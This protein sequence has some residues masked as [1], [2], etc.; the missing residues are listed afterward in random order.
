MLH[1]ILH[2]A[3]VG[4]VVDIVHEK[5]KSVYL[6]IHS[7]KKYYVDAERRVTEVYNSFVFT[8]NYRNPSCRL[9]ENL[10]FTMVC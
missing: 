3:G 2:E 6:F 4:E 9:I 5:P 7:E 10:I 1:K 8:I